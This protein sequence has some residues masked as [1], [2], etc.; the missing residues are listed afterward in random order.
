MAS[1]SLTDAQILAGIPAAR[2]RAARARRSEP[3]A[4]AARYERPGRRLHIRLTNDATLVIPVAL[5]PSLD[6]ATDQELAEVSLGAAGL[7]LHWERLDLDLGIP[8]LARL[9]LG[10]RVLLSASGA[11]GGSARSTAKARAARRNGR[12]GGRPRK[13]PR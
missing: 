12:K 3:H 4:A 5:I 8:A 1:R 7:G 10:P 2:Q 13:V 11:A 6:T 9:A